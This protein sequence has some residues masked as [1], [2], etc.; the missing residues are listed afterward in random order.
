MGFEPNRGRE[1][2][3]SLGATGPFLDD[4]GPGFASN[5]AE[6]SVEPDVSEIARCRFDVYRAD[7]VRM[8][9]T[10]FAGGDWRWRLSDRVGRIL[11]EA[12]GYRTEARCREA[13]TVLQAR[14][15]FATIS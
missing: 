2:S 4:A 1:A 14:A 7:N 13:V 15:A 8:T 11:V 3:A 5:D 9:S 6:G 10:L 12:G